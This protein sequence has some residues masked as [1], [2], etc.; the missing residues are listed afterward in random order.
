M[1]Y[2]TENSSFEYVLVSNTKN[3]PFIFMLYI[4]FKFNGIKEII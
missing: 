4:S 1:I 3:I 2:A